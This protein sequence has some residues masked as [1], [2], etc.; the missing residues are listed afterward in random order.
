MKSQCLPDICPLTSDYM[1]CSLFRQ[2]R[3]TSLRWI[4]WSVNRNKSFD[5]WTIT[6]THTH[7]HTYVHVNLLSA[8]LSN[9]VPL[10]SAKNLWAWRLSDQ[11]AA[12][13]LLPD[14]RQNCQLV[15]QLFIFI[16]RRT[17]QLN[18]GGSRLKRLNLVG[19]CLF[20]IV[21]HTQVFK[22]L[23]VSHHFPVWTL[24]QTAFWRRT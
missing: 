4:F 3:I 24:R 23:S 22:H 11:S 9:F 17:Q 18:S 14:I 20:F 12:C 16:L 8:G 5:S 1:F 21:V 15:T 6:Y 7:K 13:L 19:L 10:V 2:E